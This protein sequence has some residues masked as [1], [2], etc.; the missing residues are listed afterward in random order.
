MIDFIA[1]SELL[2]INDSFDFRKSIQ[3]Q[4][5]FEQMLKCL[6]R[7][8]FFWAHRNPVLFSEHEFVEQVSGHDVSV[9]ELVFIF[10]HYQFVH[11]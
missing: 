5:L 4:D 1:P 3:K 2:H 7:F 6:V 11:F 8:D 9:G 10:E